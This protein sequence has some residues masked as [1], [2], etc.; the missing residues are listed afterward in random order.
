MAQLILEEFADFQ[1]KVTDKYFLRANQG[2]GDSWKRIDITKLRN[3]LYAEV[4]E[5]A[6]SKKGTEKELDELKDIINFAH[7]IGTR[8]TEVIEKA[9]KE[10]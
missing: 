2:K 7:M 4:T 10:E 3:L 8:I 6:E 5:W 1:Y 9:N